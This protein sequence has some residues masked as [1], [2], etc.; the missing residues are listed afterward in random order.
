MKVIPQIGFITIYQHLEEVNS[1]PY[2]VGMQASSF[3]GQTLEQ[4]A[5]GGG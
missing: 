2:W 5:Q 4:A 3:T 1:S